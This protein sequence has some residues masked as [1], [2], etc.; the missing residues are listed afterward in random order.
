MDAFLTG[1]SAARAVA[2]MPNEPVAAPLLRT[3]E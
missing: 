3:R 1:A 2:L